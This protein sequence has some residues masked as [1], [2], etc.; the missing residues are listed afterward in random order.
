MHSG[1]RI[2]CERLKEA[3]LFRKMTM[4]D[5]AQSVGINK[6]AISQ[7]ENNKISPDPLTL[8][9]ISEALNFPYSFFVEYDPPSIIGNTYFRALYSSKK[10]DLAAQQIKAKYLARAHAALATKVRF[11]PLNL[12]DVAMD[13]SMTIEELAMRTRQHWDL[14]DAP[15]PNMVGL[16]E[17]NGIVVGEFATDSREIDAFYQYYEQDNSPTYCVILGTDKKSFFRRQFNCAHELG[18][19]L[20]H[21][22][23]SDL[24]EIDRDEFRERENEANAF[25]AAFLLPAEAFGNDVAAY[26][27][28]LSHYVELKK[29][30]NVSIMAMILRAHALEYL[31]ANQYAY[32]MRQMSMNGYRHKEPLDDIVEYK[33]PQALKQ[34]INL[35]LKNGNM[36]GGDIMNLFVTNKFSVSTNVVEELLDLEQGLFSQIRANNVISFANIQK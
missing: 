19:I 33:H 8:R 12:P 30:W 15:I 14:G 22:R 13:R 3:R 34:A 25:A 10:K 21:E 26:P 11:L 29:K 9:R 16:L 2:N 5:L 20:L 18:H 35:L 27:N 31:S 24:D 7:F 6:Q 1:N 17:R 32:L 28:R 36:S 23:Y 4:A